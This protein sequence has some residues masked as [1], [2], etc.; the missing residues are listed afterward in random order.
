MLSLSRVF[1]GIGIALDSLRANKV[2]AA[3]TILGVAIGVMVVIAMAAAITGINRS[4]AAQIETLGPKTFFVFRFF[5]G[6]IHVSDGS[7]EMSPW[8]RNPWLS[9]EEAQMLRALPG[10]R[11][12][13]WQE[14]A[15]GPVGAGGTNL[16][17]VNVQGFGPDWILTQ[18]GT[19]IA[20]RNYTAIEHAASAR[21]AVINDHL[22]EQ[23]FAGRDPIG[24]RIKVFGEPFDVIGVYSEPSSLFGDNKSPTVFIPHSTFIKVADYWK[25]WLMFAVMPEP[26]LTVAEAQDRVTAALRAYRGLK[27]TQENNFSLV[28]QDKL[29]DSFNSVT[30][31]FF[32]VMIALSMVGLMVGGVGVIA[33]MMISVTER[34]R[35]IGVRQS[36]GAT[37]GD[38]RLQFLIEAVALSLIGGLVGVLG[39]IGGSILFGELGDM[40]TVI[41]PLSIPLSFAA[42]AAVGIFFGYFPANSAAKL[43]PIEALRHE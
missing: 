37:P 40:R 13:T 36:L 18:G 9:V 35:E 17:S 3:L 23:L 34:T 10:I 28:S 27:P 4:V 29:L 26:E 22:G 38:I 7:D 20:G 33:I 12:V 24:R 16:S 8:R 25:G 30:Q 5:Q 21:V 32:L 43:D 2:R 11:S 41:V 15:S 14:N 42:A 19:I 31:G 1:E 39:G 6:G